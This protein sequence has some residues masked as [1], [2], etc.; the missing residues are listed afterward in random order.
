MVREVFFNKGEVQTR[1]LRVLDSVGF[2]EPTEIS[3]SSS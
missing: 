2:S 3:F 1:V